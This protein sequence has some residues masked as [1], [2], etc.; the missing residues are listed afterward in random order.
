MTIGISKE[1][2]E[3]KLLQAKKYSD[4]MHIDLL[5]YLISSCKELDHWLPIDENTPRDKPLLL[6][7][8]G[9]G[10]EGCWVFGQ[11]AWI[12]HWTHEEIKPTHYKLIPD[13]PL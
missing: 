13:D 9:T 1:F 2:C 10:I 4:S 3:E 11:D 6:L 12:Q 5:Q 8:G 7:S